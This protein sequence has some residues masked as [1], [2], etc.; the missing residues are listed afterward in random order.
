MLAKKWHGA[1][2]SKLH[3]T[4]LPLYM[5]PKPRMELVASRRCTLSSTTLVARSKSEH[6]MRQKV[7]CD[8]RAGKKWRV[9]P[10]SASG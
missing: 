4:E 10:F 6:R 8:K 5:E 3:S 7:S 2:P 9:E 1:C